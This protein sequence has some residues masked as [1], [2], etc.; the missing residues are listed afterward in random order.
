MP[1]SRYGQELWIETNGKRIHIEADILPGRIA[2][3]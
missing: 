2:R 3:L 1:R